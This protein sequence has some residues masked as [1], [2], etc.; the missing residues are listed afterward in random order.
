MC[1][2]TEGAKLKSPRPISGMFVYL[3]YPFWHE[4]A[5]LP[6]TTDTIESDS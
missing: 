1:L 5:D 3:M 2:N 4:S 6:Q